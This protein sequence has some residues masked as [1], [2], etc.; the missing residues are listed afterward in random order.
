MRINEGAACGSRFTVSPRELI[1]LPKI[2][3]KRPTTGIKILN[4]SPYK[5]QLEEEK[6]RKE[7]IELKPNACGSIPNFKGCEDAAAKLLTINSYK[8]CK[9][10][11]VNPDVFV[12]YIVTPTELIEQACDAVSK[13]LRFLGRAPFSFLDRYL[14]PFEN[15][16]YEFLDWFGDRKVSIFLALEK[17]MPFVRGYGWVT[18]NYV[19][20][21][22]KYEYGIKAFRTFGVTEATVHVVATMGSINLEYF[23]WRAMGKVKCITIGTAPNL[24]GMHER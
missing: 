1:P 11:E 23:L 3:G 21:W 22:I 7:A 6:N 12:D 14:E 5:N 10:E 18:I 8:N 9:N 4:S 2:V 24:A 16:S 20:Y 13:L 17:E 19:T 15:W